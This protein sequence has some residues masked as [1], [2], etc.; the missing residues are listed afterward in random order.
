MPNMYMP[1]YVLYVYVMD[2]NNNELIEQ[3]TTNFSSI[4]DKVEKFIKGISNVCIDSGIDIFTPSETHA[5]RNTSTRV[6]CGIKCAMYFDDGMRNL[7]PCGYY[8]YPR[9]STGSKTPLRL[10]NSV[11]IIDAGYRG[12]L[13]GYFDNVNPNYDYKVEKNQRLLQICSPNI[14]YPIYPIMVK[15][16]ET[17]DS[18]I[19]DGDNTRGT[20]GF[21]ST[22]F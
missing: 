19:N 20:G 8:I 22:G 17:L 14:T 1:H 2:Q 6:G 16:I 21:G 3:Y 9:S 10:S 13:V 15:H 11:G 5:Y 4:V 7:K 12:E 18:Y